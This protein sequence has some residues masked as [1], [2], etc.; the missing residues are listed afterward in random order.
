MLDGEHMILSIP[1][2]KKN[3][4][5]RLI[6]WLIVR[7]KITVKNLQ[8]LTRTLNFLNKALIPGRAFTRRMY[9]K[10]TVI[11]DGCK[12]VLQP[13]HHISLDCEFLNDCRMWETFL[14]N[15]DSKMLCRPFIDS[16]G[17]RNA[18]Q[19]QFNKD[20]SAGLVHGGFGAFFNGRWIFGMWD[21]S[22]MRVCNPSIE[23]L[24][25]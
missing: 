14:T 12:R 17:A 9:A 11:K 6:R 22:F 15:S 8:K 10:L 18:D 25:L 4:A 13:Y 5:L 21:K 19:L 1:E 7:K 24:E 3:K 2:E 20:A 23:F 16:E